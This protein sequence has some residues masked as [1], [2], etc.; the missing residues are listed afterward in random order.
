MRSTFDFFAELDGFEIFCSE[1]FAIDVVWSV[2]SPGIPF[3][4]ASSQGR[5]LVPSWTPP[6]HF[7]AVAF[8]FAAAL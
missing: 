3:P 4:F 6:E 7:L 5:F 2:L 8:P 1:G